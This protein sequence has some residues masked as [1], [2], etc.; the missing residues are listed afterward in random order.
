[1]M[2]AGVVV[3]IQNKKKT[4]KKEEVAKWKE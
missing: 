3:Y 1:L 2:V 4:V